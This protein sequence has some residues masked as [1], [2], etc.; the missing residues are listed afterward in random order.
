MK[1]G[2]E[3]KK[4]GTNFG[5]LAVSVLPPSQRF[6]VCSSLERVQIL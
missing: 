4:N 2:L 3:G 1:G 6:G 5:A